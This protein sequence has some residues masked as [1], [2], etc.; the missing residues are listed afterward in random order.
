MELS[1]REIINLNVG[2]KALVDISKEDSE[3]LKEL[4]NQKNEDGVTKAFEFNFKPRVSGEL[5]YR[6]IRMLKKIAPE[7]ESYQEASNAFLELYAE[8]TFR[9][10]GSKDNNGEVKLEPVGFIFSDKK[11]KDEYNVE[12]K[13]LF[14][15][16]ITLEGT[17]FTFKASELNAIDGL[18]M[19][20]KAYLYSL[21]E[22]DLDDKTI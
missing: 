11:S 9:D 14:D 3:L 8:R 20:D 16:K 10:T 17:V 2:F 4:R 12:I 18:T 21:T 22:D 13:K 1:L 5:Q 7:I 6:V 15:K 19:E